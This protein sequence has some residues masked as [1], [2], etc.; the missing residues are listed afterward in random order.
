MITS[1]LFDLDDLIVNSSGIHFAAFENALKSFGIK[2]F[3][4]PHDLKIK[5][6]GLRI[7]EIMELLI[8]Y[9]KLEVD[10]EE[11]LKVRNNYFMQ[12]VKQGVTPMP[13]LD[14]ILANIDKWKMK[15]AIATSGINEYVSEV[16]R[17]L[18][19]GK[20]FSNIVTG[21]QVKN[22]KPAPDVFLAAAKKL[23]S[24]SDECVVLED[25]TNGIIAAKNANMK[26]IGVRNS[27]TEAGQDLS[28]AD[29]IVNRLDEI[30]YEMLKQL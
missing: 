25:S 27:M 24:R 8:D 26:A 20:Y 10:L 6:Y 2:V 5:V 15:R 21:D 29:L 1:I 11:L 17:Q 16:V 14:V 23:K 30:T 9:F 4:I 3:N 12:F 19:L 28:K 18:K 13:G 22:S 7:R